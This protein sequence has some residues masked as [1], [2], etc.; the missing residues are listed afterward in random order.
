M[1]S[2]HNILCFS[3]IIQKGKL[4]RCT[5]RCGEFKNFMRNAAFPLS[6]IWEICTKRMA[7]DFPLHLLVSYNQLTDSQ[8]RAI[9]A[10]L[11]IALS[12]ILSVGVQRWKR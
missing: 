11:P 8:P 3:G 5:L 6:A 12:V 7:Q 10:R 2:T 1:H 9:D 4:L